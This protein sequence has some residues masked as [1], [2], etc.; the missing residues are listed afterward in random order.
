MS[1][2][3]LT[4]PET[5]RKLRVSRQVLYALIRSGELPSLRIGRSRRIPAEAVAAFIE[6][7]LADEREAS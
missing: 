6:Q 4:V 1:T 7:K 3:L 2:D 5:M